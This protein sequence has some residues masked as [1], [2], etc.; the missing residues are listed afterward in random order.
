MWRDNA[1]REL[2]EVV[3]EAKKEQIPLKNLR[4]VH[5]EKGSAY[6]ELSLPFINQDEL[7]G[8]TTIGV[9]TYCRFYSIFKHMYQPDQK[10]F[11]YLRNS[12][13]NLI[14]HMLA[15]NDAR[16]GMTKEE[17]YKK[18]LIRDIQS[19]VFGNEAINVFVHMEQEEQN[20]L[21]SGWLRS[22][23]TGS[24]LAI[25]IDMIHSLIDNSIVYHNND[26]PE[27]LLVYTSS[28]KNDELEQRL[29]FLIELFLDI[30]YHIE[31]YYE[32]HFGII[33][34]EDTMQI[35]EIAIY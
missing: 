3:L 31:I 24:S 6:M 33:G 23:R 10:E 28:R 7:Q 35:D 20:K 27:E 1:M 8:E 9:N 14:I 26:F 18:L 17:Y 15:E 19:G 32:Y 12:L 2:W 22:Y 21:M 29:K 30:Q 25:F 4:F 34:I 13:T 5:E 16:R 11:P